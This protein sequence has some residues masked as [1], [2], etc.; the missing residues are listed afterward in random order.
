MERIPRMFEI[1]QMLRSAS[2]PIRA[3]ELA[4][5]LE[6]PVRTICRDVA[7]LQAMKIPVEGEAG[8]GYVMR[9]G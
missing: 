8:I 4:E 1:I 2:R 3:D 5:A 7:S 9:R 6:V